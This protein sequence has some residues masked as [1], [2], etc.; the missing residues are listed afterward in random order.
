MQS[1][2]AENSEE[3][4]KKCNTNERLVLLNN[5]LKTWG[6]TVILRMLISTTY[7][8]NIKPP[9]CTSRPWPP[10]P[11]PAVVPRVDMSSCMT[12]WHWP[13]SHTIGRG[14][15]GRSSHAVASPH[16]MSLQYCCWNRRLPGTTQWSLPTCRNPISG[17]PLSWLA[18]FWWNCPL[19]RLKELWIIGRPALLT[20]WQGRPVRE[21]H[22][23]FAPPVGGPS[24]SPIF[25]T[26]EGTLCNLP[27][28]WGGVIYLRCHEPSLGTGIPGRGD[29]GLWW[30]S[31]ELSEIAL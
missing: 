12:W 25:H 18:M 6:M 5:H 26:D 13:Q 17:S 19:P 15:P 2:E 4:P 16:L 20:V 31:L 10:Q 9:L 23:V 3:S 30:I 11:S 28:S 27:F 7:L 1:I 14:R 24:K 21:I 8:S 22:S 29:L